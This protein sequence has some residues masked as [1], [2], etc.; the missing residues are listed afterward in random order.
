MKIRGPFKAGDGRAAGKVQRN[1]E[2]GDFVWMADDCV[3][4]GAGGE[5][6]G[7]CWVCANKDELQSMRDTFFNAVTPEEER[8]TG[9]VKGSA[10]CDGC[11]Q[12]MGCYTFDQGKKRVFVVGAGT[13]NLDDV[14]VFCR[15]ECAK[16]EGEEKS[17]ANAVRAG[18]GLSYMSGL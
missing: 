14:R 7:N 16:G 13:G 9:F 4:P 18:H 5:K 10:Q 11:G 17:L 2:R 1:M 12:R 3:R 8:Q 6:C 15:R